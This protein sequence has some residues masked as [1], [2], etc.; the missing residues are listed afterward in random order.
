METNGTAIENNSKKQKNKNKSNQLKNSMLIKRR[1]CMINEELTRIPKDIFKNPDI[2]ILELSKN[3]ITEIDEK[4]SKLQSL[5]I[6]DLSGNK[7]QTLPESLTTIKTIKKLGISNNMLKTLPI[8]II[9]KLESLEQLLVSNNQLEEIGDNFYIEKLRIFYGS[10]N[11]ITEVP[12]TFGY[13]ENL[14]EVYFKK[15]L[16]ENCDFLE[17]LTNATIVDISH[18]MIR[19]LP[20]LEKCVNLIDFNCC[21]NR[22]SALPF[23][24]GI[25]FLNISNNL[26]KT[27]EFQKNISTTSH[28]I[29]SSIDREIL[30]QKNIN[31]RKPRNFIYQR[32]SAPIVLESEEEKI[33]IKEK[34]RLKKINQNAIQMDHVTDHIYQGTSLNNDYR[35]SDKE[36]EEEKEENDNFHH[37]KIDDL[38]IENYENLNENQKKMKVIGR[39]LIILNL[40]RNEIKNLDEIQHLV[41]LKE[42][43][44]SN[45]QIEV[46]TDKISELSKL[47]TLDL[48]GNQIKKLPNQLIKLKQ[49][50]S[51]NLQSNQLDTI[52]CSFIE[53]KNIWPIHGG[54]LNLSSNP[55]SLI[56]PAYRRFFFL[57]FFNFSTSFIFYLTLPPFFFIFLIHTFSFFSYPTPPPS[58]VKNNGYPFPCKELLIILYSISLLLAS[59]QTLCAFCGIQVL[60]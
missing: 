22:L 58:L 14:Q 25:L 28:P 21:Y 13:M 55:L 34:N 48:S 41:K 39:T 17:N 30:K 1:I 29:F 54:Y 60:G 33:K 9:N 3:S 12:R 31:I 44:I 32:A 57:P 6:L 4:I 23:I 5:K 59:T 47:R 43:Y 53:C 49:L 45:N 46:I 51:L 36:E 56:P 20:N 27:I 50:K 11:F 7:I 38:F 35:D 26:I 18:N 42:L 37:F 2:T 40:S 10:Y 8:R 52:H 15:N 19:V 24:P 16:I